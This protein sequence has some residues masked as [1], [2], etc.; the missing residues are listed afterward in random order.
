M[1]SSRVGQ[2][3]RRNFSGVAKPSKNIVVVDGCRYKKG[4]LPKL[5]IITNHVINTPFLESHSLLLVAFM[6][7]I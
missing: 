2:V 1:L 5:S 6:A 4:L 3:V 7:N